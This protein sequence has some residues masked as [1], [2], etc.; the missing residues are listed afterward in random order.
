MCLIFCAPFSNSGVG[1]HE[2]RSLTRHL[3]ATEISLV[4]YCLAYHE[5]NVL[6]KTG[7]STPEADFVSA[8]SGM[9]L[10]L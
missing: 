10:L 3:H 5:E 7:L 1:A 9:F 4:G 8:L 2:G 6:E